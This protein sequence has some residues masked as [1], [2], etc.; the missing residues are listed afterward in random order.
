MIFKM[1][2]AM[3]TDFVSLCCAVRGESNGLTPTTTPGLAG[4]LLATFLAL[5]TLTTLLP[6]LILTLLTLPA[7][8]VL[9]ATLTALG[10]LPPALLTATLIFFTIVCHDSSSLFEMLT[11]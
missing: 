9:S 8:S 1:N 5:A 11:A 6:A 10:L 4:H 3:K 2:A 7:T